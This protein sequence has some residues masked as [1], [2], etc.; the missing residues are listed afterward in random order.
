MISTA[1]S[2]IWCFK[3]WK[4]TYA[5][6]PESKGK[7]CPIQGSNLYLRPNGQLVFFLVYSPNNHVFW[8]LRFPRL[9]RVD[10]LLLGCDV[11]WIRRMLTDVSEGHTDLTPEDGD[12]ILFCFSKC[13]CLHTSPCGATTKNTDIIRPTCR[14]IRRVPTDSISEVF[15]AVGCLF[16]KMSG[17]KERKGVLKDGLFTTKSAYQF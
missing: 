17:S 6:Y 14:L 2:F 7:A 3:A 9:R 5:I 10:V 15:L 11:V 16:H 12:S 8:D 13:R 1:D 4:M